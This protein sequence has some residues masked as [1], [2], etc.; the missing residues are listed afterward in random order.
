M[1]Y[2][3][4]SITTEA[5]IGKKLFLIL[6]LREKKPYEI[7]SIIMLRLVPLK[8]MVTMFVFDLRAILA[9]HHEIYQKC[10]SLLTNF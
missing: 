4:W 3:T 10:L 1:D 6:A 2:I 5:Q 9:P 7:G 8:T